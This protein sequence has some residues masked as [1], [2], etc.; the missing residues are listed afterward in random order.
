MIGGGGQVRRVSTQCCVTLC[1]SSPSLTAIPEAAVLGRE[2][3][4][5]EGGR[6]NTRGEPELSTLT[7]KEGRSKK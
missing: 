7:E 2:E 5:V 6:E 3:T 1:A 4:E